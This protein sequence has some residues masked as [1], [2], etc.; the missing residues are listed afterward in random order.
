MKV[1]IFIVV[2]HFVCVNSLCNNRTQQSLSLWDQS[3]S[4]KCAGLSYLQ[5]PG[6]GMRGTLA[7]EPCP[8]HLAG[9]VHWLLV[10]HGR[11]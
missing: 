8:W 9:A 4:W 7:Q 5:V 3:K 2:A 11:V 6:D 10:Q 1:N